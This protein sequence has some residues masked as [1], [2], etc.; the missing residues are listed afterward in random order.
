MFLNNLKTVSYFGFIQFLQVLPDEQKL[1]HAEVHFRVVVDKLI[2]YQYVVTDIIS[3]EG[4]FIP[5]LG[6]EINEFT[7]LINNV[8]IANLGVR[9]LISAV[10]RRWVYKM[11]NKATIRALCDSLR[12]VGSDMNNLIGKLWLI[13]NWRVYRL[14]IYYF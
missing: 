12:G 14:F 1:I 4:R 9:D 6:L 11:G 7:T 10:I 13:K 5:E 8:K 3:S 2:C